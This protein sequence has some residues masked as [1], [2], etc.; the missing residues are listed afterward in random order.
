MYFFIL[1]DNCHFNWWRGFENESLGIIFFKKGSPG[2]SDAYCAGELWGS[3]RVVCQSELFVI[4]H[5]I[6]WIYTRSVQL[7]HWAHVLIQLT[8]FRRNFF[9]A[10]ETS[11]ID[12][13]AGVN[14]VK[15]L[16]SFCFCYLFIPKNMAETNFLFRFLLLY[17]LLHIFIINFPGN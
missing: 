6:K 14:S 5:L 15:M 7:Y 16:F 11:F 9:S 4:I 17:M 8:F 1:T 13:L 3:L 12:L 10:N 2:D